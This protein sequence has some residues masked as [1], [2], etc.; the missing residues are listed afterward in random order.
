MSA[1]AGAAQRSHK[2][3]RPRPNLDW[4]ESAACAGHNPELFHTPHL[5][6]RALTVCADCPVQTP[7]AASRH[8]A[9]GIWGGRAF[10]PRKQTR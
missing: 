6:D 4:Q 3:P 5:A 7:C 9:P 2:T 8:G 1:R 10:Y